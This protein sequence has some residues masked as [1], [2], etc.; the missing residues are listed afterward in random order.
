LS[1]YVPSSKKWWQRTWF[2]GGKP[3]DGAINDFKLNGT[4]V[5][6]AIDRRTELTALKHCKGQPERSVGREI[7][8]AAHGAAGSLC[9]SNRIPPLDA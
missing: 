9:R 6:A 2:N 4:N 8:Q 3:A 1:W 5:R 7:K